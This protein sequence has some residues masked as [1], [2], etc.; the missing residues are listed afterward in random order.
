MLYICKMESLDQVKPLAES[1]SSVSPNVKGARYISWVIR[2]CNPPWLSIRLVI[3]QDVALPHTMSI[4]S[5]CL[6]AQPFQ[7]CSKACWKPDFRV[8]RQGNSSIKTTSRLPDNLA[9]NN[10]LRASK[11]SIQLE[12]IGWWESPNSRR[13]KPKLDNCASKGASIEPDISKA[14][15]SRNKLWTR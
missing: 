2:L 6:E 10:C 7:K 14:K 12:G 15:L 5:F 11:A 4:I 8:S 9:F 13:A 3:I 1:I